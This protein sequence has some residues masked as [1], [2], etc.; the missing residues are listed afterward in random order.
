M[1][2][3]MGRMAL[4]RTQKP[5]KSCDCQHRRAAFRLAM[6]MCIAQVINWGFNKYINQIKLAYPA[7]TH[8]PVLVLP[9]RVLSTALCLRPNVRAARSRPLALQSGFRQPRPQF[10]KAGWAC[11][12]RHKG[13]FS[14][15]MP[16]LAACSVCSALLQ[17]VLFLSLQVLASNCSLWHDPSRLRI[18]F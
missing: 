2:Q 18:L 4:Q 8:M 14:M 6:I 1:C 11:L 12:P 9:R 10:I 13:P 16:H 15:R 3:M 17:C 5:R 7:P